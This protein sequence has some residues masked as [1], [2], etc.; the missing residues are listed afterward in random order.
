MIHVKILRYV[1]YFSPT[2]LPHWTSFGSMYIIH[3]LD[4]RLGISNFIFQ[5][6]S[7]NPS[8]VLGNSRTI[9]CLTV[10]GEDLKD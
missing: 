1:F 3:Y 7:L 9:L 5:I 4:V 10:W 2:P 8:V 6:K